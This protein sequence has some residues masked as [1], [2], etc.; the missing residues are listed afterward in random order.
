MHKILELSL[1]NPFFFQFSIALRE[2]GFWH[3]VHLQ[4]LFFQALF[5]YVRYFVVV[6]FFQLLSALNKRRIS[7]RNKQLS[8]RVMLLID[9]NSPL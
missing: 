8:K 9:F 1:I 2:F 6:F 5:I 7:L 3:N 4:K